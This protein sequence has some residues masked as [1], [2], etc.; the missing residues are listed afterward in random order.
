MQTISEIKTK[1]PLKARSVL[2]DEFFKLNGA[3]SMTT[4]TTI[5]AYG[6]EGRGVNFERLESDAVGDDKTLKSRASRNQG[7]QRAVREGDI[8]KREVLKQREVK[9][10]SD[11]IGEAA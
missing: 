3:L 5:D 6:S 2:D 4:D 1:Q 9:R 11:I 7:V 10:S 8:L